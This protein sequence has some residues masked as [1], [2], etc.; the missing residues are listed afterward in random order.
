MKRII[1]SILIIIT[2]ISSIPA[3]VKAAEKTTKTNWQIVKELCRKEG[4][5]KIKLIDS[6]NTT[7][8]AFWNL[9]DHRKGKKY[10]IVEKV[11]SISDGS[12]HGWYSTKTKGTKYII[13]YNRKVPKGKKVLSYVIWNPASNECD[14][15]LY[16]V[17]HRIWR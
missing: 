9:V 17:D 6:N 2:V 4:Y 14:D 7:D 1:I 3:P 15:I 11:V 10:I 13:G 5:K 8:K 16:V 12:G